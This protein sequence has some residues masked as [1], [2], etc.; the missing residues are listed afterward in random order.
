VHV[1]LKLSAVA[2]VATLSVTA[3]ATADGYNG[4]IT[5]KELEKAIEDGKKLDKALGK[6]PSLSDRI[7]DKLRE[8]QTRGDVGGE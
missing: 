1:L 7:H 6:E 5:N 3:R 8:I 4:Y 2:V